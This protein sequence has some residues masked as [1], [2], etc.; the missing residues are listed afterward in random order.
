MRDWQDGKK[1]KVDWQWSA[2]EIK[3]EVS[4]IAYL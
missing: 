2:V 3:N 4:S 1:K